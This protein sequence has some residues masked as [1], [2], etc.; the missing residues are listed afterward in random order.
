MDVITPMNAFSAV[1]AG[2]RANVRLPTGDGLGY[3]RLLFQ[4]NLAPAEIGRLTVTLNTTVLIDMTG[5]ELVMRRKYFG[6]PDKSAAGLFEL[7]LRAPVG[8]YHTRE[9]RDA[10]SIVTE[11]GDV[12]SI[13]V[14][15]A[16]G[17]ATPTLKGYAVTFAAAQRVRGGTVALRRRT[18]MT[19]KRQSF[20]TVATG[21]VEN[22]A[23]PLGPRIQRVHIGG[24][25]G[26]ID[27][28][29]IER[30]SQVMFDS[31]K[32]INDALLEQAGRAPQGNYFHYDPTQEG[33]VV[34]DTLITA[35]QNFIWRMNA[36][37]AGTIPFLFE[38]LENV[39]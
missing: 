13:E 19:I 6:L 20:Q 37:T 31:P 33:Y 27:H 23:M 15:I 36:E 29:K 17:A 39:G 7:D 25:S 22:S 38:R 21:E 26:A 11:N 3:A 1:G 9:G 28:L 2:E 14:A 4:S 30:N 18:S 24:G 5:G 8:T 35:S 10:T 16:A 34:Q 32:A 12:L